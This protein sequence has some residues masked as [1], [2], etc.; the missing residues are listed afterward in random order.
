MLLCINEAN[1]AI[2]AYDD[3][4]KSFVMSVS[5]SVSSL[6][7]AKTLFEHPDQI[8]CREALIASGWP[9]KSV[10]GNSLNVNIMKLRRKLKAIHPQL[11]INSYPTLGYKLIVPP[12]VTIKQPQESQSTVENFKENT[13]K[14]A[15][16]ITNVD[17]SSI[18][19][20]DVVISTLIVVYCVALFSS[21]Y[22]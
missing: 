10:G 3:S 4:T 1:L 19:W 12:G 20:G 14:Q 21:L 16:E 9:S 11:E 17:C 15:Q 22:L 13:T 5:M 18:R 7:I 2:D 8:L 6:N